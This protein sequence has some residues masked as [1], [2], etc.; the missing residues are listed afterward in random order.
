MPVPSNRRAVVI[1]AGFAGLSAAAYLARDGWAVTVVEKNE[2]SGGRASFLRADGF[3]FD[4]GPSRY[5]MPDVFERWFAGFGH[6]PEDF[7]ELVRLD[8]SYRIWFGRDERVDVPAKLSD[9]YILFEKLEPGSGPRLKRF[10]EESRRKYRIG[11]GE[12]ARKPGRSILEFSDPRILVDLFRLHLFRSYERQVDSLFRDSRI[13]RILELPVFFLGGTPAST[14]ALYSLMSYADLA[15][16]TWYPMG[17]M[18]EIVRAM[19]RVAVEQ[20][21]TFRYHEEAVRIPVEGGSARC[22][23]TTTGLHEADAVVATADYHH[24][25]QQLLEPRDR[26]YDEAYW[27]RRTM[28]PSAL[29]FFL[30]LDR[31]VDSLLHH[32]L[33][34]DADFDAFARSIYRRPAWP[35]DPLFYVN[36]PS[37]TDPSVAPEG[38]ESVYVLVPVAPGLEDTEE[39]R[40]RQY[41]LIMERLEGLTGEP[42]REHVVYKRS[43]AH[44]DFESRYHA[45]RGNAYGLA[46][47]L[48]QTAL[49]KPR[50]K[51]RKVDNLYYAGQLTVPGPGV[52]WA[53]ISGEIAA[54]EIVRDFRWK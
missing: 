6:R 44:R 43:F 16:G 14:P 32:N 46:N 5:W 47:T 52:P 28:A 41:G 18:H 27:R 25:E 38:G 35:D 15:L 19:S 39:A 51:S 2:G 45:Y 49:L 10:L 21:V 33:F 11:M 40:E 8:P 9:L 54:T 24:V 7:C 31:R 36:V 53:L 30:G 22:V 20:G 50:M 4:M 29:I 48:R 12:W 1:G 3:G 23:R 42:M 37:R 13:K 17:G 34:F 26:D